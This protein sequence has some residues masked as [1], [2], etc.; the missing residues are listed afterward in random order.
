MITAL[1]RP[2]FTELWKEVISFS[3]ASNL[4]PDPG[5]VFVFDHLGNQVYDHLNQPVQVPEEFAND[6]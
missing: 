1:A 6:L 2:L 5:F 4:F 3:L